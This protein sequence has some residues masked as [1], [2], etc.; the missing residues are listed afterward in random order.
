MRLYPFSFDIDITRVCSGI[1]ADAGVFGVFAI[2]GITTRTNE[3]IAIVEFGSPV[4][5]RHNDNLAPGIGKS[6]FSLFYAAG[7]AFMEG[8]FAI[9]E[10]ERMVQEMAF[11]VV[12]IAIAY[13]SISFLSR[14][15]PV[16][17]MTQRS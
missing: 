2:I 14:W 1:E 6:C 8:I 13:R 7:K 9:V 17:R 16:Y 15:L 10:A 5:L 4:P 11:P 3:G 12:S